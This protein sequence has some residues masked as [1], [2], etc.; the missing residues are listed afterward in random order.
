MHRRKRD[1]VED[2]QQSL[3]AAPVLGATAPTQD[4]AVLTWNDVVGEPATRLTDPPNGGASFSQVQT[5]RWHD[6]VD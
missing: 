5:L 6:H 4:T 3:T 1:R 2:T